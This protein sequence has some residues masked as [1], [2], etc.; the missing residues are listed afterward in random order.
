MFCKSFLPNI[1]SIFCVSMFSTWG[2]E[3]NISL[4]QAEKLYGTAA[5]AKRDVKFMYRGWSLK[6]TVSSVPEEI[7]VQVAAYIKD[8]SLGFGLQHLAFEEGWFPKPTQ[9][10][11]AVDADVLKDFN[12]ARHPWGKQFPHPL[13]MVCTSFHRCDVVCN[14]KCLCVCSSAGASYVSYEV[15]F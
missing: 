2:F 11:H 8:R 3:P 12:N 7:D 14:G 6:T 10:Q 4:H 1:L 15:W 9:H 5:V 13:H